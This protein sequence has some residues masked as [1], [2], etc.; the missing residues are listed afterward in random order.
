MSTFFFIYL[1]TVGYILF[2]I[3]ISANFFRWLKKYVD[4]NVFVW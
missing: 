1:N 4:M 3:G 2:L